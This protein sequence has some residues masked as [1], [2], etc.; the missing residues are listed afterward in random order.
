M[1]GAA[2]RK[3]PDR[4]PPNFVRA[5]VFVDYDARY[6]NPS[7]R[8]VDEVEADTFNFGHLVHARMQDC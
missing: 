6:L 1:K 2:H 4:E 5:P 8:G 3:L 7:D